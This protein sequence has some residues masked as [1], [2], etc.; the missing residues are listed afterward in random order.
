MNGPLALVPSDQDLDILL[1]NKPDESPE[2][3]EDGVPLY[4]STDPLYAGYKELYKA[5]QLCEPCFDDLMED[6]ELHHC[7]TSVAVPSGMAQICQCPGDKCGRRS[8]ERGN[9]KDFTPR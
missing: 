3:D 1:F 4:I 6:Q 7:E 8:I 5:K 9:G 2:L